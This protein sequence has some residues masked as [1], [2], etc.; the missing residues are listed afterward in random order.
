MT[1]IDPVALARR[2]HD[3]YERLA[4]QFGYETRPDTRA[5]DPESKNGR[6]MV[7]VCGQIGNE[8]TA[9]APA[10]SP[11]GPTPLTDAEVRWHEEVARS[12]PTSMASGLT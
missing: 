9:A 8:L 12:D 4:P 3:L 10:S 5:F 6:L 2:F 11:S 7:A 1:T